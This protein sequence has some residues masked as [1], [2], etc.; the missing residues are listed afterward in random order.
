MPG[1][2]GESGVVGYMC[3]E[4]VEGLLAETKYSCLCSIDSIATLS[5]RVP[6]RLD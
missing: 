4:L 2:E 3:I 6:N 5:R 1:R